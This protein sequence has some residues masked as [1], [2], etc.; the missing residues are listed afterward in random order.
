METNDTNWIRGE[1][2]RPAHG[3]FGNRT[4]DRA[5]V[6]GGMQFM[7]QNMLL[8]RPPRSDARGQTRTSQ[9]APRTRR[10]HR[11]RTE[12]RECRWILC[13]NL[14]PGRAKRRD[15]S[16]VRLDSTMCSERRKQPCR[17][18]DSIFAQRMLPA[19]RR[20]HG[21]LWILRTSCSQC[22]QEPR[23]SSN[24][25]ETAFPHPSTWVQHK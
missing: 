17:R 13:L 4:G 21:S 6:A 2:T 23:A 8:Q 16:G 15:A 19:K 1:R 18:P 12:H 20:I 7:R 10:G 24:T 3:T 14:G 25:A 5:T 22:Q 11:P 9:K